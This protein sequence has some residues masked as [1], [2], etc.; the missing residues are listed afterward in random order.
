MPKKYMMAITKMN[1]PSRSA[2][3]FRR[4]EELAARTRR[5]HAQLGSNVSKSMENL[6]IRFLLSRFH[7]RC[8][9]SNMAWAVKVP[10]HASDNSLERGPS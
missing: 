8:L 5:F 6:V 10:R 2:Q 1:K 7:A 9:N 3:Y 4:V